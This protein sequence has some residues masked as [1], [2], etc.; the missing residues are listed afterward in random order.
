MIDSYF[1]LSD[2]RNMTLRPINGNEYLFQWKFDSLHTPNIHHII[3][4]GLKNLVDYINYNDIWEK[5]N[6]D[7]RILSVE[8]WSDLAGQLVRAIKLSLTPSISGKSSTQQT[9]MMK[10]M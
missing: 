7:S 9:K 4:N 2:Q 10:N 3:N 6:A 5:Y 1:F 8:L